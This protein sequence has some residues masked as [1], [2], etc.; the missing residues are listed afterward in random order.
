[1]G[2]LQA[3]SVHVSTACSEIKYLILQKY[4]V[5]GRWFH[6][7]MCSGKL[8]KFDCTKSTPTSEKFPKDGIFVL[9]LADPIWKNVALMPYLPVGVCELAYLKYAG[10]RIQLYAY[11]LCWTSRK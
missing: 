10:R 8:V 4:L 5:E 1:M 9:V 3:F 2:L 11:G 6:F 7:Y